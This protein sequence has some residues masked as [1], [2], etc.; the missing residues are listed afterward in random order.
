MVVMQ[1][2]PTA[3]FIQAVLWLGGVD[4]M[5]ENVPVGSGVVVQHKG[6][7]Y[8][9]TA[10]HVAK[11]CTFEP[12][13]RV[14]DDWLRTEWETVGID[15]TADVAVAK[16]PTKLMPNLTPK[17]GTA[18]VIYGGIGRAVG[19]PALG[20]HREIGHISMTPEGSPIPLSVLV[21]AYFSDFKGEK[22]DVHYAGGYVNAGFSGGAMLFPADDGWTIAGI[23]THKD[24]VM[25]DTLPSKSPNNG[26]AGHSHMFGESAGLIRYADYRV[27]E[28]LIEESER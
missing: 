24:N 18:G 25:R 14:K 16:T 8:L 10:L 22:K 21:A 9:A 17:Y 4:D 13:I 2:A 3:Q 23:I 1:S 20:D 19:F 15:E 11:A 7:E 6:S 28:R 5:G 27:V 26:E 12:A